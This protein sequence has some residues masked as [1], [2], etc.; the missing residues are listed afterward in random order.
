MGDGAV[1]VLM[2]YSSINVLVWF[3]VEIIM[4]QF[5][6]TSVIIG[7]A[8]GLTVIWS[9]IAAEHC[10]LFSLS[11]S[12]KGRYCPGDGIV[13]QD[14][15]P[16]QCRYICL[17]TAAFKAYN[18]NATRGTC[19]RFTSPCPL[20][21]ADTMME[22]AVFTEKTE[23]QCYQWIPVGTGSGN[24]IDA[25]MI[26]TDDPT[27]ILC[28]MQKDGDDAV[29]QYNT[30]FGKCYAN[31]GIEVFNNNEGYDCQRLRI[32]EDCTAFWVSY[33]AGDLINPRAVTAG[34]VANGDAVYVTKFDYNGPPVFS[35]AGHYVEG[36]D[37]A[38][39]NNWGVSQSSRVMWMLV[40][41]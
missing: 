25:R 35:L 41:L 8:F 31:L 36:A 21:V 22:F 39:S 11:T 12:Y 9:V 20:A 38:I 10:K 23:D 37:H 17:Q 5:H 7:T 16:H 6:V 15:F 33:T 34:N 40:V 18:Y 13:S 19:T 28:S 2:C 27:R 24:V 30:R 14:Q 3:Q 4:L 32:M 1:I 26:S 29:C